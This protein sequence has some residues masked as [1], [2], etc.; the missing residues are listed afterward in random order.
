MIK[1]DG[2]F[3]CNLCD[4]KYKHRQNLY[5]HR[6]NVHNNNS[7]KTTQNSVE[8]SNISS[9]ITQNDINL[10]KKTS[11]NTLFSCQ[12]CN[13]NFTRNDNK[14]RHEKKCS[15]TKPEY[16]DLE[17]M[18]NKLK[19]DLLN[20][21]NTKCKIHPKKLQRLCRENNISIDQ[22][23]NT[24]NIDQSVNKTINNNHIIIQLGNENL[25]SILPRKEKLNILKR[26]Y[27]A[28]NEIIE[29][30][31]FND[32]YPQFKNIAITNINNE[33][34]YKYDEKKEKMILCKKNELLSEIMECR[35]YDIEEF[36]FEFENKLTEKKKEIITNLINHIIK[37]DGD[38]YERRKDEI[39]IMIF[40]NSP[41]SITC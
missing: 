6:R 18:Y 16:S 19:S 8:I 27:M 29:Q 9:K 30:V 35:I 25:S 41:K 31:H 24:N 26:G 34:A 17:N 5:R 14:K 15:Q 28:L 38:L 2:I 13:K 4:K 32:K 22:S 37:E 11:E 1:V 3:Q 23:I 21:M 33:Y 10:S 20:L 39:K 7:S 36:Y 12:Y 40:N